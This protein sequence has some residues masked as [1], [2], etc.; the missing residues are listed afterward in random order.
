VAFPV[1]FDT[2]ALYGAK[3]TDLILRTAE[4]GAFRPLWSAHVLEELQNAL[5]R[6]IAPE[7]AARR[8]SQMRVAF[9]DAEVQGYEAL[10]DTMRCDPKDRHVLAAAVRADAAI[11]VTF[12]LK[13][14]PAAALDPFDISAVHPDEFLLDQLDLYPAQVLRALDELSAS[15]ERPPMTVDQVLAALTPWVPGFAAAAEREL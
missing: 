10:I 8:V 13:D 9:P 15:Y 12:N 1:F 11:I 5:A 14:F 7:A 6:R 3:L 4:F 2:C